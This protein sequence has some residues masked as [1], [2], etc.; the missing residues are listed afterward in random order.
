MRDT[1]PDSFLIWREEDLFPILNH[2]MRMD[3][4][5]VFIPL[6]GKMEDE[7]NLQPAYLDKNHIQVFTHSYIVR[8]LNR[9]DDFRCVGILFSRTYWDKVMMEPH[10]ANSMIRMLPC[11]EV[12]DEQKK[13]LLEYYRLISA[14]TGQHRNEYSNEII[15]HLI[16]GMFYELGMIYKIQM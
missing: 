13:H 9:S 4:M 6:S 7:I 5:G 8:I 12:T 1:G 3:F 15:R 14:N 16:T 2:P 10:P 11:V